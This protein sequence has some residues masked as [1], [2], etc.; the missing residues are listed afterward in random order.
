MEIKQQISPIRAAWITAA[1]N[2]AA[3]HIAGVDLLLDSSES[4][5]CAIDPTCRQI[6]PGEKK[7]LQPIFGDSIRYENIRVYERPDITSIFREDRM[8]TAIGS[9]IYLTERMEPHRNDYGFAN[10][11]YPAGASLE[12]DHSR[13]FVH[14]I[15]H[16]W[17]YQTWQK[18][19][20]DITE[21]RVPQDESTPQSYEY[22]I[23]EHNRFAHFNQEQ[24]AEI[25][26]NYFYQRRALSSFTNYASQYMTEEM[27]LQ[28]IKGHCDAMHIYETR[29][30][31]ELPVTTHP[32]CQQFSPSS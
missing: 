21:N 12:N 18:R 16:V 14:E 27:K 26:S 15:T 23:L 1:I 5:I 4:V 11:P 13:D 25:V 29:L 30:R 3:I 17:Q 2:V 8:A 10:E 24:Q 6:T 20:K 9:N 28:R 32:V 19:K 7:M 22:N 31:Q